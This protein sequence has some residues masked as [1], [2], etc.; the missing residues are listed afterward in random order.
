MSLPQKISTTLFLFPAFLFLTLLL[1]IA[2]STACYPQAEIIDRYNVNEINFNRISESFY[3]KWEQ[4]NKTD[5][6]SL[7]QFKRWEYYW[8]FRTLPDGSLPDQS[9]LNAEYQKYRSRKEPNRIH[10]ND[11][12]WTPIGPR[13]LSTDKYERH[14][15]GRI[16]CIAFHPDN[17][18]IVWVGTATSG[19]WKS[20]DYGRN[21]ERINL[22]GFVALGISAIAYSRSSPDVMYAATGDAE[23]GIMTRGYSSGLLRSDDGG[24]TWSLTGFAAEFTDRLVI[25]GCLVMPDNADNVIVSTNKGI[26]KS[27]DGGELWRLTSDS[28]YFKE[29][30]YK[31]GDPDVMYTSTFFTVDNNNN[32]KCSIYK[33]TDAG[34]TWTEAVSFSNSNRIR[35]AVCDSKPNKI[36]A[37]IST[38]DLSVFGGLFVSADEGNNWTEIK[39]SEDI[40]LIRAQGAYNLSIGIS[41]AD[42]NIIYIGGIPVWKSTDGGTSWSEVSKDIHVDHHCLIFSPHTG[43][44]FSANDGGIFKSGGDG[45]GNIGL[46][47]IGWEN[48][49]F[50]LNITQF[51]RIGGNPLNDN[52]IF[53]GSQDN[54]SMLFA[55][56]EWIPVGGGDGME[57]AVDYE[58]PQYVYISMQKGALFRSEDGGNY[59]NKA[60]SD[61]EHKE[62]KPWLTNFLLHPADPSVIYL[63]YENI[64]KSTD[65]GDSWK[66]TSDFDY[67]NNPTVNALAIAPG[68]P[69][70]IYFA[71][72]RG[73]FMT[74]DG[75]RSWDLLI[76]PEQLITSIAVDSDNPQ[77]IWA[78]LSG[79]YPN[80][81]IYELLNGKWKNI[82][83]SLPNFPVNCIVSNIV[84]DGEVYIGTDI[85]VFR[86][87]E[88]E[89]DWLLFNEAMPVAIISELE[90]NYLS[91]KL[92]AATYGNGVWE[93]EVNDCSVRKPEIG[94][95]NELIICEGGTLTVAVTN[96]G[97]LEYIWSN[98]KTGPSLEITEAGRYYVTAIDTNGIKINGIKT[99]VK[100]GCGAVSDI[101]NVR[102]VESPNVRVAILGR[103]P[104]CYGGRLAVRATVANM[105]GAEIQ[106]LW[107]NGDTARQ[108]TLD[109]A[110]QYF[111]SATS[112]NGCF[113]IS[114][115]FEFEILPEPS[116][117]E[118]TK[119]GDSLMV[120]PGKIVRWI[121]DGT[122]IDNSNAES[123]RIIKLGGYQA[124]IIDDDGCK[125][126]SEIIRIGFGNEYD[127]DENKDAFPAR[128][129]PNPAE[130]EFAI[131]SYFEKPGSLGIK[132]TDV[133]GRLVLDNKVLIDPGYYSGVI[134]INNFSSGIYYLILQYQGGIV[135]RLIIKQ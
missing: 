13:E 41:P 121:L 44:I 118:I 62:R 114:S 38:A 75:G 86:Y 50:G 133:T 98:G 94:D 60:I 32:K 134:N 89:R 95:S 47:N 18:D 64:W 58:N 52:M 24:Q 37:L 28:L 19:L 34:D 20:I 105:P 116:K 69:D 43:D 123:I 131:E 90:L 49:S 85:G 103:H 128:I 79:Y 21:W 117:P 84:K 104:V 99:N 111:V 97:G 7:K 77:H 88:S 96:P 26:Y 14:G 125:V 80:E 119:I 100:N 9:V 39:I 33:S 27:T 22:H 12:S 2:A 81:K 132:L 78:G 122:D 106:Y 57:C 66:K 91:G 76:S 55:N 112:A 53:G 63:G 120:S 110:G 51:Y 108:T 5:S 109:S 71:N 127:F 67:P 36:W 45:L 10:G 6:S 124:E 82:S 107:S 3:N 129:N 83:G 93:A 113:G 4:S 92:R 56:G 70:Y 30:I 15:N 17:P 48:I 42:E 68:N 130:Y 35:L 11:N 25:A 23:A 65:R 16:N 72:E 87:S 61:F 73:L 59:F 126:K 74:S 31:P 102:V 101:I 8:K 29:I 1:F 115:K 135:H 40:S 46:G 54:G